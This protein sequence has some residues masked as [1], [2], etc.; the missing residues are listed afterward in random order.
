MDLIAS[1]KA[2]GAA[3]LFQA[4]GDNT[5][6]LDHDFRFLA[7][8]EAAAAYLGQP[9]DGLLGRS[10]WDAFPATAQPPLGPLLRQAMA[11]R[12]PVRLEMAG[13]IRPDR[14]V[15]FT[16][17]PIAEGLGIAF[18]DRTAVR[19]ATE[20]LQASEERLRDLLSTLDL[21][22]SMA[23]DMDGT[24]T[25]WSEGCARLYGWT[26][27]EALGRSAHRLLGTQFPVPVAEVTAALER[28]GEWTG[29]LHQV[30]RDGRKLIVA[31]RKVLRRDGSGRP[32]AVLEALADVTAQRAAEAALAESEARLALAIAAAEIGIWDWTSP[33][34]RLVCTAEVLAIC[35]LDSSAEVTLALAQRLVHPGDRRRVVRAFR[36]ARDPAR[37]THLDL[38][39]RIRRP[40]GTVRQVVIQ[41]EPL[42]AERPAEAVAIRVVGTLRDVTERWQWQE[43]RFA[44]E[45]RLR[46][47]LGA[48]RMAVWD[49]DLRQ[50]MVTGSAELPRLLGFPDGPLPDIETIRARF[51]PGERERLREIGLAALARG[52][53]FVEAE[54][55]YLR[56]HDTACWLML[57]TEFTVD[58]AGRA[59]RA[60]GVVLDITERK[61]AEERQTLLAREVDHR[62]KNALAV[63]QAALRLT[64]KEDPASY[65]RA[66]E[67]RV[68]ALARAQTL[69]ARGRWTGAEL[70]TLLEDELAPFLAEGAGAPRARL[71]GPPV[72]L[73]PAATQALSMA[74]HE[75]ATN[76][77]KHGALGRSGGTVTVQ[78]RVELEPPGPPLLRLEWRESGG[79]PVPGSPSRRGFGTRVLD[80][81]VRAQLGGKVRQG[82]SAEGIRVEMD[83]PLSGGTTPPVPENI[84]TS[85]R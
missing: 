20:S 16:L 26:A 64:P 45:A 46:L 74:V 80:G 24:I 12:R 58:A 25:F 49:A 32:V 52:E 19:R 35:G 15:E 50:G 44:S 56:P 13:T 8:D 6:A 31:A 47:A 2:A 81:T 5:C 53:Q 70:R 18:R 65:M 36:N 77:V 55:R 85:F 7:C 48:G 79:P 82:W 51:A 62:A 60:I 9:A 23:R 76:A 29:D 4:L 14:W 10:I 22:N 68:A 59:V 34:A 37:R 40:D 66:V 3:G 42:F 78:W 73:W 67:G 43:E 83:I 84:A 57:R 28:G 30:A 39:C 54:F 69:L 61:Q 21:G 63:V 11:D 33:A 41:G 38:A 72:L 75:L 1:S 17:F 71:D 27:A